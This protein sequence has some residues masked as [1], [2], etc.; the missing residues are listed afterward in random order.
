MCRKESNDPTR[1]DGSSSRTRF[2]DKQLT[3]LLA[4]ANMVK[5]GCAPGRLMYILSQPRVNAQCD[6]GR[7][8]TFNLASTEELGFTMMGPGMAS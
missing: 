3:T 7:T 2:S 8:T 1:G 5:C 4:A 6:S